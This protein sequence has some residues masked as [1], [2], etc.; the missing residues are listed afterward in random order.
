MRRFVVPRDSLTRTI[1]SSALPFLLLLIYIMKDPKSHCWNSQSVDLFII[2]IGI[3][4]Q[5][6]WLEIFEWGYLSVL[7]L[8]KGREIPVRHLRIVVL[9]FLGYLHR[10]LRHNTDR[11]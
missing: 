8:R 10:G 11:K 1:P 5:T 9:E 3:H 2:V 6:R 7:K 4:A